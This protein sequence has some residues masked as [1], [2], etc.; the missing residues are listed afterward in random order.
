[1]ACHAN[2]MSCLVKH[3]ASIESGQ[4]IQMALLLCYHFT[5]TALPHFC[6]VEKMLQH[7]LSFINDF[8]DNP[9]MKVS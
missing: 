2:L 3:A 9:S 7:E 8:V 5:V 1:M 4:R 6:R